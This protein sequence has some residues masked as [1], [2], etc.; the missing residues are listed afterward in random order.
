MTLVPDS[1]ANRLHRDV[2]SREVRDAEAAGD[3]G[4]GRE[5]ATGMERCI[6]GAKARPNG[7]VSI[8]TVSSDRSGGRPRK[9]CLFN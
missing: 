8:R 1:S 6:A 3:A 9:N 7:D 5:Q 2:R 4:T